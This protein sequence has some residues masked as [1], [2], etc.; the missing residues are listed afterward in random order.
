MNSRLDNIEKTINELIPNNYINVLMSKYN[1]ELEDY[2]YID[3]IIDFSLLQQRGSIR[4]INKYDLRLRYGGLLIKIY[5]KNGKWYGVVKKINNKIYNISFDN[6]YIFYYESK[7]NM[8]SNWSKL[9]LSDIESG[10][11]IIN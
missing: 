3:N 4:Y 2:K 7:T 6:N 11:Y 9:F 8:L 5:D 1:R 10:K